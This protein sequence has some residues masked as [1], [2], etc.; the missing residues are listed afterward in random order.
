EN[1]DDKNEYAR[2]PILLQSE[3]LILSMYSDVTGPVPPVNSEYYEESQKNL[4]EWRIDIKLYS[5]QLNYGPWTDRNRLLLQYFFYPL[6]FRDM[7]IVSPPTSDKRKEQS[8]RPY[9]WLDVNFDEGS[10]I[11]YE[12]PSFISEEGYEGKLDVNLLNVKV[13]TSID[14]AVFLN[15]S[16]LK[17][18]ATIPAP[19]K[20]NQERTMPFDIQFLET[21]IF[22]LK[23]HI[24]LITDLITDWTE[25][26]PIENDYFVPTIY[27]IN[28]T[29][30]EYSILMCIN[31]C[32]IINQLNEIDQNYIL[33][34]KSHTIGENINKESNPVGVINNFEL[35][36]DYS[37][38]AVYNPEYVD[39]M[40]L[41]IG[42]S[43]V[44]FKVFGYLIK[45]FVLIADNYFGDYA[46]FTTVS[47]YREKNQEKSNDQN[48]LELEPMNALDMNILIQAENV[49][50]YL[51]ESLYT[52]KNYITLKTKLLEVEIRGT[53]QFQDIQINTNPIMVFEKNCSNDFLYIDDL[54]IYGHRMFGPMPYKLVYGADW[55]FNIGS[56]VGE[57][58]P[59]FIVSFVNFLETFL[60][61]FSDFDNAILEL[62]LTS[63]FF[64]LQLTMNKIDLS[65]W[66]KGSSTILFLKDGF[67]LQMDNTINT[68]YCNRIFLD[69]PFVGVYLLA[70]AE[71]NKDI[72]SSYPWIEVASIETNLSLCIYLKTPDWKELYEKQVEF[73][74]HQDRLTKRMTFIY[75]NNDNQDSNASSIN[76]EEKIYSYVPVLVPPFRVSKHNYKDTHS[77]K[78]NFELLPIFI[79]IPI[80]ESISSSLYSYENKNENG[81]NEYFEFSGDSDNE[82]MFFKPKTG[83]K[84]KSDFNVEN[85]LRKFVSTNAINESKKR[86]IPYRKYLNNYQLLVDSTPLYT[87]EI[88]SD[89]MPPLNRFYDINNNN[90]HAIKEANND[91]NDSYLPFQTIL[92]NEQFKNG[93]SYF[94]LNEDRENEDSV[95][96]T[97]DF[98][99]S[100]NIVITPICIK[101]IQ[102]FVEAL[103]Y[104]RLPDETFIDLFQIKYVGI[105]LE[106]KIKEILSSFGLL[107]NLPS[108][109]IHSIQDVIFPEVGKTFLNE[110]SMRTPENTLS[111]NEFIIKDLFLNFFISQKVNIND[112]ASLSELREVK[113]FIEFSKIQDI[114]R[115][116]N[117]FDNTSITGILIPDEEKNINTNYYNNNTLKILHNPTYLYM[118][119]D[120]FRLELYYN[121]IKTLTQSSVVFNLTNFNISIINQTLE[122]I[123]SSLFR[124]IV[125]IKSLMTI[126]DDFNN[127]NRKLQKLIATVV[128]ES[129]RLHI[130]SNPTFLT[131]PSPMW[132]L[133]TSPHKSDPGWKLLFHIRYAMNELQKRPGNILKTLIPINDKNNLYNI[134]MK[135]LID[136]YNWENVSENSEIINIIFNR[137]VK[138]NTI[139]NQNEV[140][141]INYIPSNLRICLQ[142]GKIQLQVFDN[143]VEKNHINIGQIQ[144]DLLMKPK[145]LVSDNDQMNYEAN[146]YYY[147]ILYYGGI[148]RINIVLNGNLFILAKHSIRAINWLSKMNE[149]EDDKLNKIPSNNTINNNNNTNNSTIMESIK[150]ISSRR[151]HKNLNI[152]HGLFSIKTICVKASATTIE[153]KCKLDNSSVSTYNLMFDNTNPSHIKTI[154]SLNL[155]YNYKN[156]VSSGTI[157]KLI[158]QHNTVMKVSSLS[159]SLI[160]KNIYNNEKPIKNEL[161][162]LNFNDFSIH[163]GLNKLIIEQLKSK[164]IEKSK[165]ISLLV[166]LGSLNINVLKSIILLYSIFDKWSDEYLDKYKYLI[167]EMTNEIE[168][169]TKEEDEKALSKNAYIQEE[170][171]LWNDVD[172]SLLNDFNIGIKFIFNSIN[173]RMD[174]FSSA[175]LVIDFPNYYI[176][177]NK[178]GDK[179]QANSIMYL[180]SV[181]ISAPKVKLNLTNNK[182]IESNDSDFSSELPQVNISGIIITDSSKSNLGF[183]IKTNIVLNKYHCKITSSI[184]KAIVLLP[185]LVND[186]LEQI[187]SLY[188]KFY[189]YQSTEDKIKEIEEVKE[190]EEKKDIFEQYD[191]KL[192]LYLFL[193]D[194]QIIIKTE[195][196]N[197]SFNITGLH[198]KAKINDFSP[199]EIE[200]GNLIS[201]NKILGE[202][203]SKNIC[204]SFNSITNNIY[205]VSNRLAYL[206]IDLSLDNNFIMVNNDPE[207]IKQQINLKI[208]DVHSILHVISVEKFMKF[209][210]SFKT[211]I[212]KIQNDF[213]KK[214]IIKKNEISFENNIK[215]ESTNALTNSNSNKESNINGNNN[216]NNT[217]G[218]EFLDNLILDVTI[219]RVATIIPLA[220]INNVSAPITKNGRVFY[221]YLRLL[222]FNT[223]FL[224][225]SSNFGLYDIFIQFI[226]S[227]DSKNFSPLAHPVENR[228]ALPKCEVLINTIK[229]ENNEDMYLVKSSNNG[230]SID[231]NLDLSIYIDLIVK[232]YY[233][234]LRRFSDYE[235]LISMENDNEVNA[236]KD[237]NKN[238]KSFDLSILSRIKVECEFEP[239]VLKISSNYNEFDN[240]NEYGNNKK[241]NL[242][243]FN[244]PKISFFLCFNKAV[245][246]KLIDCSNTD[247]D[248]IFLNIDISGTE[249]ILRPSLIRFIDQFVINLKSTINIIQINNYRFKTEDK[250]KQNV[251][252]N[253][254]SKPSN[255]KDILSIFIGHILCVNMHIGETKFGLSCQP[256]SN[257]M[258]IFHFNNI[259]LTTIYAL[260]SDSRHSFIS[261][262]NLSDL[263][264]LVN[265][266]YSPEHFFDI[267]LTKIIVNYTFLN[268]DESILDYSNIGEFN[269]PL[270]KMNFNIRY[271]QDFLILYDVW[272]GTLLKITD[273]LGSDVNNTNYAIEPINKS[274][275]GVSVNSHTSSTIGKKRSFSMEFTDYLST[276]K[277]NFS[278]YIMAN[279]GKIHFIYD[280]SQIT[281]KGDINFEM[282]NLCYNKVIKQNIPRSNA[283][284]II[285]S[286]SLTTEGKL[287]GYLK[288]DN[289]NMNG[290]VRNPILSLS[291]DNNSYSALSL[292]KIGRIYSDLVYQFD[293]TF[294]LDITDIYLVISDLYQLM[295]KP[296]LFLKTDA[297]IKYIKVCVS[298]KTISM[299]MAIYNRFS[300]FII[301]KQLL[302]SSNN[303]ISDKENEKKKKN[304]KEKIKENIIK[305]IAYDYI[306]DVSSKIFCS[307]YGVITITLEKALIVAFRYN[308]KDP[309]S[310]RLNSNKLV[311]DVKLNYDTQQVIK[312]EDIKRIIEETK[313]SCD[314]IKVVKGSYKFV[315]K[316]NEN[317]LEIDKWFA[318]LEES[319][320]KNILN[321]PKTIIN[322]NASKYLHE[323]L[324]EYSFDSS[325]SEPIDVALNFG[326]YIYLINVIKLYL[327]TIN[328]DSKDN[329]GT[330]TLESI[331]YNVE[332]NNKKQERTGNSKENDINEDKKKMRE[333]KKQINDEI[334][335]MSQKHQD[336]FKSQDDDDDMVFKAI[337][338]I[339]LEPQ[340][341]VIGDATSW[342]WVDY[343][344]VS[345]EKIPVE[346]YKLVTNNFELLF[347]SLSQIYGIVSIPLENS[348][349]KQ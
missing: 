150:N 280:L 266:T 58:H 15:G 31:E 310:V 129:N 206:Y 44:S 162:K 73:I 25:G 124:W 243:I 41:K 199:E 300:S 40:N 192:C 268:I 252:N 117:E 33:L 204:L 9:A 38:Y 13:T 142:I 340:L 176:E 110:N 149:K 286:I 4:P 146:K 29:F 130:I 135:N 77:R 302:L 241:V 63:D 174:L 315:T 289:I 225:N 66:G 61:H 329:P 283:D 227:F 18:N 163:G 244:F 69:F 22:L 151:K 56:L 336:L 290:D 314:G 157:K 264:L 88:N 64:S 183:N 220:D 197:I 331:D 232:L 122:L 324:I 52:Y 125:F 236:K 347:N 245:N 272:V 273:N 248:Q 249:N 168:S 257:A 309:D 131:Q 333:Y 60:Y 159:S 191:I 71:T 334:N 170:S 113:T 100:L 297:V 186:E 294:L 42:G 278:F 137:Q 211:E 349:N 341:K 139:E 253:E 212:Q 123:S 126:L 35:E 238:Q 14:Y 313:F 6:S 255:I 201:K 118:C 154:E 215:E 205:Q 156:D 153:L 343:I 305:K 65:I 222:R 62:P 83:K 342:E 95:F 338:P 81:S 11:Y 99:K 24:T 16:Q 120:N 34:P 308:F 30:K 187:K 293:K 242:H 301:E 136:W 213:S 235:N 166:T 76:E 92:Q 327:S 89:I 134:T 144:T 322:L 59:F 319:V 54:S 101:I 104:D 269:I 279:I 140:D 256:D 10:H 276:S 182:Y 158:I 97:I 231:L 190:A 53:D 207:N 298:K 219:S 218:F 312:K 55:R 114:F 47:E 161:V 94:D 303:N 119:I 210:M 180:Y 79:Q 87:S 103:D 179:T 2:V 19:L 17:I 86:P 93:L 188:N 274:N 98:A 304:E 328:N 121:P 259:S 185:Y 155:H 277:N 80:S 263:S 348:K 230:V 5:A 202:L 281:G 307:L 326:L 216:N 109:C 23:D 267:C 173:L 85:D 320:S 141:I 311:L 175:G 164:S 49:E 84:S 68:H 251:K 138:N 106:K 51:P 26:E 8:V 291:K 107:I 337:K 133:G 7:E 48:Q 116:I 152:F 239:S 193:Q 346:I 1:K 284:F 233:R 72:E 325:F 67:K 234:S 75:E 169:N 288:I 318:Y 143:K 102:E 292:N 57:V 258:C 12:L 74:R 270:I 165:K 287:Q 148:S 217:N 45:Y 43:G 178:A 147:D 36:G 221:M 200:S 127:N 194:F 167:D 344:G 261:S 275:T 20:W 271:L 184:I 250:L 229:D 78:Q 196:E 260:S 172:I 115:F 246:Q 299:V 262:L 223:D 37:F 128:K 82:N 285:K 240:S 323:K 112:N 39:S 195:T 96:L 208:Q 247:F 145:E 254:V 21:K 306:F 50:A 209:S 321:V 317:S 3:E 111:F 91:D 265:N 237:N 105:L 181:N 198:G 316:Q 32:N 132:R 28:I 282:I 189:I 332:S 226:E 90:I 46:S 295:E 228:I 335:I 177:L 296:K 203:S 339:V 214:N 224:K 160:E 345:K 171:T 330:G 108:L 70:L 27:D